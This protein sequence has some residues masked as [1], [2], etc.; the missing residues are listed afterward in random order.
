M[1]LFV[2]VCLFMCVCVC[3]CVFV[4]VCVCLCV[5]IC[6]CVCVCVSPLCSNGVLFKEVF[7]I[8]EVSFKRGF[9][10][11]HMC[12]LYPLCVVNVACTVPDLYSVHCPFTS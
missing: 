7:C 12:M 4:C 11:R 1:R 8:S 10:V 3:L 2:C 9:P 6:V 5:C